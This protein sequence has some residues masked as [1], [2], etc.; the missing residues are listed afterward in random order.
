MTPDQTM[1]P[2]IYN[3]VLSPGVATKVVPGGTAAFRARVPRSLLP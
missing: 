1:D 2:H 3:G